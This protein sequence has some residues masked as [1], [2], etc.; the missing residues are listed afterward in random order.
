[1]KGN[2]EDRKAN[3]SRTFSSAAVLKGFQE[4]YTDAELPSGKPKARF[5]LSASPEGTTVTDGVLAPA[6]AALTP[7]FRQARAGSCTTEEPW[8][9]SS[10]LCIHCHEK[11]SHK[12][13]ALTSKL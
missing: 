5:P 3:I 12:V 4:G 11:H 13:S 2:L 6:P 10:Y 9:R 7:G 8:R 1:M